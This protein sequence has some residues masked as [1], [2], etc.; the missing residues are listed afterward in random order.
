MRARYVTA[1]ILAAR[2][3]VDNGP[4]SLLD[5]LIHPIPETPQAFLGRWH[6]PHVRHPDPVKD[7]DLPRPIRVLTAAASAWPGA[8]GIVGTES[9]ARSLK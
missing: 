6:G 4:V 2:G 5:I 8:W 3:R 7:G 1:T 9:I